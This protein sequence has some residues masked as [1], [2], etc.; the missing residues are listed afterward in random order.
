MSQAIVLILPP[1]KFNSQLSCCVYFFIFPVNIIS[2]TCP[3]GIWIPMGL[4]LPGGVCVCRGGC[5]FPSGLVSWS[6]NLHDQLFSVTLIPKNF[7]VTHGISEANS[8]PS[9]DKSHTYIW[10]PCAKIVS[11]NRKVIG[12]VSLALS[13]SPYVRSPVNLEFSK[14]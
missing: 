14:Q 13:S 5:G 4:V 2:L 7:F 1:V 9:M 11:S 10:E 12:L 3:P 6:S 8:L